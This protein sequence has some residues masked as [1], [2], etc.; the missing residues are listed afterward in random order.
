MKLTYIIN[1]KPIILNG[2][3]NDE[4]FRGEKICLSK[5]FDD[6]I[7]GTE[8]ENKGYQLINFEK[9]IKFE[10]LKKSITNTI[11][12]IISNL[13]PNKNLANFNLEKYHNF[14]KEDEHIKLDKILKRQYPKNFGFSDEK[15]I[16]L[17]EDEVKKPLGYQHGDEKLKH[18][19]IIRINMPNSGGFNPAHKDIY[20]DFDKKGF[21]PRMINCWIPI[22]G[23]NQNTGLP[24]VPESHNFLEKEILRTKCNAILEGRKYSVNCIK[25]WKNRNELKLINPNYGEMILFSSHL[26]HGLGI[27]NNINETRIS[28]EFRLHYQ[29]NKAY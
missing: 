10:N 7:I 8:W 6:L 11:K 28:L 4:F 3:K 19:I 20:E 15:I 16:E 27:N 9:Y 13:F 17:I 14:I 1:N 18:W 2:P 26:I 22:C 29:E 5:E 23:V 21:A 12:E 24:L 25:S